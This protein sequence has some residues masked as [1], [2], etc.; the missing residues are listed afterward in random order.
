M[1]Q[2]GNRL[3]FIF[4]FVTVLIDVIGFGIIIPVLPQLIVELTGDSIAQ[5]SRD[6]GWLA[7]AYALTQ[8]LCG[9]AIGNLSDQVGRR[10]VLIASMLAFGINYALMGLAPSLFWLFVGR[11]VAGITGATFAAAY[12]YVA[13]TAPPDRR[14]Q[15][16]GLIGMAFGLGFIIGPALGGLLG[17]YGTRVP[18]FAAAGL[19][20]ANAL[21]GWFALPESLPPERRR[22]FTLARANPVGALAAV[23]RYHPVV[24]ALLSTLLLW[25]LAHQALQTTWSFYG[26]Y[27]FGWSPAEVG[28]SLAAVGV[29]AI[30]VQGGLVHVLIPRWGERRAVAVALMSGIG[31]FCIYAAA[32]RGWMIYAGIVVG[33]LSGLVLPSLQALMTART[34]ETAQGE[35]QGLVSSLQSFA[36]ILGPPVMTQAFAYFT[37]PGAPAHIPGAAFWLAALLTLGALLLFRRALRIEAD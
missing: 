27:R 24:I 37:M 34:P 5:A 2:R 32:T 21:F 25:Q 33:A 23:R 4:I 8:F 15:S 7:F 20:L 30:A 22:R 10:P 18:F 26:I 14:A 16:F 11:F 29:A 9:P 6:A 3:A 12:A 36:A 1:Q 35:L 28:L 13:D 31:A 17:E 19:A